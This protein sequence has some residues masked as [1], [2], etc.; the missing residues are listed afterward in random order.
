MGISCIEGA[1]RRFVTCS[2]SGHFQTNVAA[3][4]RSCLSNILVLIQASI[5]LSIEVHT[6]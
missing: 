3:A 6:F 4:A 1:A 2:I 5:I